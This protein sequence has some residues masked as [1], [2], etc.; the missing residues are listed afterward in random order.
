MLSVSSSC[1]CRITYYGGN[2]LFIAVGSEILILKLLFTY[3]VY[4]VVFY[5]KYGMMRMV[6]GLWVIFAL[7]T[8]LLENHATKNVLLDVSNTS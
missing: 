4:A 7:I 2:L 5:V 1:Y 3:S 6:E 8:D